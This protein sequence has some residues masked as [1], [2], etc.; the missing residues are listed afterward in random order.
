MSR[1]LILK[2]VFISTIICKCQYL[3]LCLILIPEVKYIA[4]NM[5]YELYIVKREIERKK[6]DTERERF[7]IFS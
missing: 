5:Y 2:N 3:S 1:I 7:D 6:R 4:K